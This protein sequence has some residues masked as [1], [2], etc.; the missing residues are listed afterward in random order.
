MSDTLIVVGGGYLSSGAAY[1]NISLLNL[2]ANT[3]TAGATVP[4]T[5]LMYYA[6]AAAGGKAYMFGGATSSATFAKAYRYDPAT[7]SLSALADMPMALR[8]QVAVAVGDTIYLIGGHPAYGTPYNGTTNFYKYS[9]SGNN[10]VTAPALPF[11]TTWGNGVAYNDPAHGWVIYNFGGYNASAAVTNQCWAYTTS[12]DSWQ[13]CNNL[14]AA[15][16]SHAGAIYRDTLLAIC[17]YSSTFLNTVERGAIEPSASDFE[18][19][20][21]YSDVGTPDSLTTA[22]RAL[23]DS[24]AIREVRNSTPTLAELMTYDAV[25]CHSNYAFFDKVALGDTLAAYVDAGRGVVPTTFCFASGWELGGR[26]MTGNYATIGLAGVNSNGVSLGWYNPGHPVMNGVTTVNESF[27]CN[28]AFV[29]A[30]TVA[31]WNNGCAYVGVSANGKVVGVN[32]YPGSEANSGRNGDWALVIHNALRYVG[33]GVGAKELDPL[34]PALSLRLETAPNPAQSRVVVNYAVAGGRGVSVGL[35]DAS[36][37][38][39][40]TLVSG[41]SR[42]GVQSAVWN[43]TDDSG[44]RVAAGTYFCRLVSEGTTIA[45]KVVVQ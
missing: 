16:R 13:A 29:T 8:S 34:R 36:G 24:V 44:A 5:G 43:M 40:R 42:S 41:A 1:N 19:L 15:R 31:K 38:L 30:D 14:Q 37:K 22:L 27:T 6:M 45:R 9:I 20:W 3:W 21:L 10:Y 25:G 12:N 11:A 28:S 33:G 2:S 17:G 7:N 35:Y 18:V 32:S 23:G 39:V 26:V 4:Q